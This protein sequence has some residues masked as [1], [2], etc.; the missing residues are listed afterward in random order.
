MV[1]DRGG[2]QYTIAIRDQFSKAIAD[3]KKGLVS[4]KAEFAAFAK[5]KK[6]SGEATKSIKANTK[7]IDENRAALKK[8]DAESKAQAKRERDL[9]RIRAS[10]RRDEK[11]QIAEVTAAQK[12]ATQESLNA[13]RTEQRRVKEIF[14]ARNRAEKEAARISSAMRKDQAREL[15]AQQRQLQA[16]VAARARAEKEAVKIAAAQKKDQARQQANDPQFQAQKRNLD[17]LKE[18]AIVRAQI[19]NLRQRAAAQAKSGDLI[20]ASQSLR[21]V[22]ELE[23][24]LSKTDRSARNL[25][26]TFR[27]LVGILAVFTIARNVV[28]SFTDMVKAGVLFNDSILRAQTSIAGLISATADVRNEFGKSVSASEELALSQTIARKQVE[29]LRQDALRTTATFEQLAETFQVAVAPGF[30]AGLNIDEIRKLTVSISQAAAAIGLE[31]N[32]LAEEVRSLLSGTIQARTTRIATALG[33]TNADVRRLRE[34]GQLFD[35]LQKKLEAFDKAAQLVA[36]ST[37]SG[38]GNLVKGAFSKILGDAAGPLFQNLLKLGNELFDKVLTVKDA[39]G[40]IQPNPE[41]VKAFEEIFNAL[42][43]GVNKIRELGQNLGFKGLQDTF[44]ALGSALSVSIQFAVGFAQALIVALRTVVSLLTS[45]ADAF[46]LSVKQL[47]QIAA[48]LGIGL[49]VLVVWKN[50]LGLIGLNFGNILGFARALIPA[51]NNLFLKLDAAGGAAKA[52][53]VGLRENILLISAFAAAMVLVLKGFEKISEAIFGVDLDLQDTIQ[54]IGVGLLETIVQGIGLLQK[55]GTEAA[56]SLKEETISIGEI[57]RTAILNAKI[58]FAALAEN[59]AE[60]NRLTAEKL[61]IERGRTNDKQIRDAQFKVEQADRET[62]LAAKL[63]GIRQEIA[64]IVGKAAGRNAQG[65][66]F[67]PTFDLDKFLKAQAAIRAGKTAFQEF[68]PVISNAGQQVREL[69]EELENLDKQL[70]ATAI[71]LK[72]TLATAGLE[73][74]SGQISGIFT[75]RDVKLG[76]DLRKIQTAIKQNA[77]DINAANA[78]GNARYHERLRLG[79]DTGRQDAES[80]VLRERLATLAA[81]DKQDQAQISSLLNDQKILLEAQK[82]FEDQSLKLAISKA[83][84]I[85]AQAT[86]GLNRGNTQATAELA[87]QRALLE[88][89][90]LR[91][92]SRRAA[93]VQAQQEINLA[94]TELQISISQQQAKIA[95]VRIRAAQATGEEAAV[96]NDLLTAL[97]VKVQLEEA[98]GR[99]K[100]KGLELTKQEAE[101]VANG[102][103]TDGLARGF[104]D[105]AKDLPTKFQAGIQLVRDITQSAAQ[106]I[107]STIISAF[108]PTDD[109]S[110]SERIGRFLL[111][112]SQQ[113]LQVLVE[114]GIAEAASALTTKTAAATT[115]VTGATT[116]AGIREASALALTTASTLEVT[117]ATTAAAIRTAGSVAAAAR[118]GYVKAF[119]RG[120]PVFPSAAHMSE[121]AQGLAGGGK[122]RHIPASDTVPA[123]L[124]PGEFVVNKP[125]V[126]KIGVKFFRNLQKGQ[127]AAPR[128]SSPI[129]SHALAAGMAGGGLVSTALQR[130]QRSHAASGDDGG[131]VTVLP[132]QVAG[133][134]ELNRQMAGGKSAFLR[135]LRD[136][137]S[138]VNSVLKRQG[139]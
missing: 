20:G 45:V 57:G 95:S 81:N 104:E 27:R 121:R 127:L 7:A 4:A 105:L 116:A 111:G 16:F 67:D 78:R 63:L 129:A 138:T 32:Q 36:R 89:Q 12:R 29:L 55:L 130:S 51:F 26:F 118:G 1:T 44:K 23:N 122:P 41:V 37:L 85:A 35:F 123:W 50:T 108:D 84:I 75:D 100:L 39:V 97:Q 82:N 98:S 128:A 34:S 119:A 47:G 71:E 133:E 106:F 114:Q 120:G 43:D 101:L 48:S 73:G 135:F 56:H 8:L 86:P 96:L 77:D 115:E 132:V 64:N 70:R 6:D 110:L 59:E 54:L 30:A 22:K 131:G 38:I 21:S 126:D 2:L 11:R 19:T 46:G 88:L 92:D 103:L 61:Q 58:L 14:D 125:T 40:N 87:A 107:S 10:L 94:R 13:L 17:A 42:N 3:F 93:I 80:I 83:A 113:M 49:G 62:Q 5:V 112:I 117:N 53:G 124:T 52:I 15:T 9:N 60:L 31:Q 69:E 79:E 136:N 72:G 65:E 18:E 137:R 66:G 139:G 102:S 134:R 91:T 68:T 33:I 99:A 109:T 28:S 24:S 76:E 25:F 90:R 74:V